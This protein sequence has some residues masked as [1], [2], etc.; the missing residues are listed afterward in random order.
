M[1]SAGSLSRPCSAA[2]RDAKSML[3]VG[4]VCANTSAGKSST[5]AQAVMQAARRARA[6]QHCGRRLESHTAGHQ[7]GA[8]KDDCESE[9]FAAY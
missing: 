7:V 8:H 5:L 1:K 3:V 2:A 4:K 9:E 6:Q